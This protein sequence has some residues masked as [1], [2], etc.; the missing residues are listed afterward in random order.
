MIVIG[1]IV[2]AVIFRNPHV[3]AMEVHTPLLI[4]A[5]WIFGG[6]IALA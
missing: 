4:L 6:L 1:G 3:V 2:G 5:A